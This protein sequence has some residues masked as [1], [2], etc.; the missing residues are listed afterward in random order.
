MEEVTAAAMV[1]MVLVDMETMPITIMEQQEHLLRLEAAV[2]ILAVM[3]LQETVGMVAV[4]AVAAVMMVAAA[5]AAAGSLV[6]A[7][8]EQGRALADMVVKGARIIQVPPLLLALATE[9]LVARH[10][11]T[12]PMVLFRSP[13]TH[14]IA[15]CTQLFLSLF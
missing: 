7:E 4:V 13:F 12:A 5:V 11:Q 2:I 6:V 8:A 1:V 3:A 9:L 14:R 15:L 10:L